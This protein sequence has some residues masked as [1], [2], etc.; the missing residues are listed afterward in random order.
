MNTMT[1]VI[2]YKCKSCQKSFGPMG[3]HGYMPKEGDGELPVVCEKCQ[4]IYVGCV[5]GKKLETPNCFYC[6][7]ELT[8][9]DGKCPSCNSSVMI[10]EDMRIKGFEQ[11]APPVKF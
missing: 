3:F 10:F 8:F 2:T 11:K 1:D 9:F 6:G 4:N 7:S 5:K